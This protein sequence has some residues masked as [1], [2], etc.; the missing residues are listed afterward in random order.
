MQARKYDQAHTIFNEMLA[1][2]PHDLA[3]RIRMY[4]SACVAQID[5]GTTD[6]QEPRRALRLRHLAVEPRPL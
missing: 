2:A 3:D 5:K 1:G 4:I 6:F